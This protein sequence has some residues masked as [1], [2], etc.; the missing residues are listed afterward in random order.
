MHTEI[1]RGLGIR[2]APLFDQPHSLKL[3]LPRKFPPLHDPP[4]VPLKHLTR[5]LRNRVQAIGAGTVWCAAL[6]ARDMFGNSAAIIAALITAFYPYYV[7]HDTALQETGLYTFLTLA[8]LLLMRVRRNGS[9]SRAVCA[10]LTLGASVPT[11]ANLAPFTVLAPLWLIVRPES[12]AVLWQRRTLTYL[13]CAGTIALM[14]SPWL[15]RSYRLTGS[16]TLST[17]SGFFLWLGNNSLTF[18][19]YPNESVDGL[20]KVKGFNSFQR[21]AL[22]ILIC[23]PG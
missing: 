5:C 15:V 23:S 19:K 13:L 1:V 12:N 14:V 18:S 3:E 21:Q 4:P 8:V 7:V 17:E 20:E 10:G 11:R 22:Q 2:D 9:V 16:P 6:I